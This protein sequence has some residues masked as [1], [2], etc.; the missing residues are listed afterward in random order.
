MPLNVDWTDDNEEVREYESRVMVFHLVNAAQSLVRIGK[1]LDFSKRNS[2]NLPGRPPEPVRLREISIGLVDDD[3]RFVIECS[4]PPGHIIRTCGYQTLWDVDSNDG[5]HNYAEG[6]S[7][8]ERE[9][10]YLADLVERAARRRDK[11]R[12]MAARLATLDLR[13]DLSFAELKLRSLKL[14]D[15]EI[16]SHLSWE[17]LAVKVCDLTAELT[18]AQLAAATERA[19]LEAAQGRLDGERAARAAETIQRREMALEMDQLRILLQKTEHQQNV[20]QTSRDGLVAQVLELQSERDLLRSDL[21]SAQQSQRELRMELGALRRQSKGPT[22]DEWDALTRDLAHSQSVVTSLRQELNSLATYRAEMDR[23]NTAVVG[24]G[25]GF[26]F[27]PSP[28][29]TSSQS[30]QAYTFP[31]PVGTLL[32]QDPRFGN[33]LQSP[34]GSMATV[35]PLEAGQPDTVVTV[36]EVRPTREEGEVV[37]AT[38]QRPHPRGSRLPV[39]AEGVQDA[40]LSAGRLSSEPP[41]DKTMAPLA[42]C[43]TSR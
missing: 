5:V 1:G 9:R 26:P 40:E 32:S 25:R 20:L 10:L 33:P 27:T 14:T 21:V 39:T 8:I 43:S 37:E 31:A 29:G 15:D 34:E 18:E 4:E 7:Q 2:D 19:T 3:A 22:V 36:T 42:P 28:T 17:G 35:V 24:E 16:V 41:A 38:L 6:A 12:E 13:E 23:Q 11:H 30:S